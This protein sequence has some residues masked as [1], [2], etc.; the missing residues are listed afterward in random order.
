M[1]AIRKLDAH[2]IKLIAAGEVVERPASIVKELIEN[3]LDAKAT[4]LII[5]ANNGG[6]DK[7]CIIDN[8]TGM[9]EHDAE[10]ASELHTTSKFSLDSHGGIITQSYGFRGEALAAISA[11]SSF[12]LV[13][14][15]AHNDYATEITS[16]HG[17]NKEIKKSAGSFGTHITI[18][19]LFE[20]I[21]ARRKFLKSRETE[22]NAIYAIV[23]HHA[24]ANP[25]VSFLL[26]HDE[27][28]VFSL[29][30]ADSFEHRI[31]Q[32]APSHARS[33]LIPCIFEEDGVLIEGMIT[34]HEY[35]MYD[36]SGILF[37]ING[38]PIKQYKLTHTLIKSYQGSLPHQKYPFACISLTMD[39]ELFDANIHP[40][41]EEVQFA[42]PKKIELLLAKAVMQALEKNHKHSFFVKP[43]FKTTPLLPQKSSFVESETIHSIGREEQNIIFS[44][45]K[46]SEQKNN[47]EFLN[48]RSPDLYK[49]SFFDSNT[50]KN[51]PRDSYYKELQQPIAH[52]TPSF[53]GILHNTYLI[54]EN[55]KGLLLIDQH[56]LHERILYEEIKHKSI[57]ALSCTLL[58]PIAFQS[59]KHTIEI[60]NTH[61]DIINQLHISYDTID[62]TM[63]AIRSLPPIL[64]KLG[65]QKTIDLIIKAIK[66]TNKAETILHDIYAQIACKNAIKA[67]DVI[68][69]TQIKKLLEKTTLY[70]CTSL[71]PHGRPTTYLLTLS[72]IERL[73][74]RK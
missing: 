32:C 65:I 18:E 55:E 51:Q 41:K 21:P 45:I 72:E 74:K 62:Y 10:I 17:K 35:G 29:P 6:K 47:S 48:N 46:I 5:Q 66:H 54:L 26:E 37:I 71:C 40:R 60:L 3:S 69:D 50:V 33:Y 22:W 53:K 12:S 27:K 38:R 28:L 25:H 56:A 61:S 7:I 31:N 43:D 19:S 23:M 63:L 15:T 70:E 30:K 67:G 4:H 13:T 20:E 2:E 49:K 73:F 36:R 11:V 57:D 42:H 58:S 8:G 59:D 14:R 64:Q 34:S 24:C 68:D 9:S 1:C 16:H 52:T 44:E 39:P